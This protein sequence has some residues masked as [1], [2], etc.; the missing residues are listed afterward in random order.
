MVDLLDDMS[1]VELLTGGGNLT[2]ALH[3]TVVPQN[4]LNV[5]GL[6]EC[7]ELLEKLSAQKL[8]GASLTLK[9]QG[10]SCFKSSAIEVQMTKRHSHPFA[11]FVIDVPDMHRSSEWVEA[12]VDLF[13]THI[14][15]VDALEGWVHP[16]RNDKTGPRSPR[17]SW[18]RPLLA[19]HMPAQVEFY[20]WLVW[21][22]PSVVDTLGGIAGFEQSG[23]PVTV[24]ELSTASGTGIV[25][26]LGDNPGQLTDDVLREWRSFLAPAMNESPN[27]TPGMWTSE[28]P[29]GVL[30]E[31]W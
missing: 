6:A 1:R 9:S 14:V 5:E 22:P 30:P 20:G 2:V 10:R 17:F 13:A 8:I 31:D 24:R 19:D 18:S 3:A 15:V 28:R 26:R 12:V 21:V 4:E 29:V 25:A 23:L 11:L 7:R 27:F 16:T